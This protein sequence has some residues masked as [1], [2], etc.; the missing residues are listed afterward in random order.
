MLLVLLLVAPALALHVHTPAAPRRPAAALAGRVRVSPTRCCDADAPSDTPADDDEALPPPG[1]TRP[2]PLTDAECRILDPG[3]SDDSCAAMLSTLKAE[4]LSIGAAS[5]RGESATPADLSR[6]RTAAASLEALNPTLSPT[7]SPLAP[8]TYELVFSDTQL[9]RSSPFFMA[10]RAVCADG[11]QQEQY[12]WFCDMHRGALAI[13]TIGKVRQIV[14]E[15]SLT[16]EFEV[17]AGAIPF[18]SDL[19]PPLVY[20]GGLP[21]TIDGA[22]VSTTSIEANDG[23]ALTLLMDTVEIKGSNLPGLRQALDSGLSLRTRSLG[24][25]LETVL[26]D[27]A[28]PTPRLATTFLDETMRICRDQDEKLFVYVRT[29]GDTTPTDYSAAPSDLGLGQL[30]QGVASTLFGGE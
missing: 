20:S 16:S 19:T 6:A 8:G 12:D 3:A 23:E 25:A 22:I 5:S 1:A 2:S 28:N 29:G 13:S 30:L 15:Q 26:P 10:G 4:L 14:S 17:K 11:K 18:L 24:G 21:L 9:F 7:L 27:Y